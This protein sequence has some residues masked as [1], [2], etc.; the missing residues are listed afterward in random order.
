VTWD[1]SS[2]GDPGASQPYKGLATVLAILAA[3]VAWAAYGL[4]VA[5]GR[6]VLPRLRRP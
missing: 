4:G 1:Q 5:L 6:F 3:A 2:I